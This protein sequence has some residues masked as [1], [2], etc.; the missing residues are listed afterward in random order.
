MEIAKKGDC[1]TPY[2]L[3]K[4]GMILSA[5]RRLKDYLERGKSLENPLAFYEENLDAVSELREEI[6]RQIRSERVDDYASKEL[7]QLRMQ[8]TRKTEE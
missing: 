2:Q 4:V 7:A 5:V 1:L 6:S 3:E 8:I